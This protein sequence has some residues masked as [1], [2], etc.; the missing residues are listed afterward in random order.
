MVD[1]IS[2]PKKTKTGVISSL[3]RLGYG[4]FGSSN[5][6][7][8]FTDKLIEFWNKLNI[9]QGIQKVALDSLIDSSK[10]TFGSKCIDQSNK[11]IYEAICN[12]LKIKLPNFIK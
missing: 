10:N 1:F 4:F 8:I 2:L 5:N 9:N 6:K 12:G 11:F 3:K 7:N